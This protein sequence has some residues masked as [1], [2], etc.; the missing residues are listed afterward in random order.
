MAAV[1]HI[2]FGQWVL[3]L[4]M[5]QKKIEESGI[6]PICLKVP[7]NGFSPNLACGVNSWT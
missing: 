6:S 7:V 5:P 4:R 2:G 3:S 1:R